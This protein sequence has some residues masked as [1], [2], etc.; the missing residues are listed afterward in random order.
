MDLSARVDRLL[1]ELRAS[2]SPQ[3]WQRIDALMQA[4]VELYGQAL[5]RVVS[6]LDASA[7][8]GLT[9]DPLVGSVMALHGLHPLPV[10]TRIARALD[11]LA[12]EI[13]AVTLTAV[14]DGVARLRVDSGAPGAPR[15]GLGAQTRDQIVQMVTEVAPELL[16]VEIDGLATAPATEPLFQIDLERSRAKG[17]D[18]R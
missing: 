12:R 1:V 3:S 14:E 2:S 6:T 13:G 9:A 7:R 11:D 18:R 8:H 16:R 5:G 10:E 15:P 4:V 17:A